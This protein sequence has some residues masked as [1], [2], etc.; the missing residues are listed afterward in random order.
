[1]VNRVMEGKAFKLQRQ[2]RKLPRVLN[3]DTT[4]VFVKHSSAEIPAR[5]KAEGVSAP[6]QPN[7]ELMKGYKHRAASLAREDK[8]G[9]F[10]GQ[11]P[12]NCV[13]RHLERIE[14]HYDADKSFTILNTR[15]HRARVFFNAPRTVYILLYENF[16]Q[17][18]IRSSFPHC[19]KKELVDKFKAS[20]LAWVEFTSPSINSG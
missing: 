15:V 17:Q 11:S 19:D 6:R 20:C 8:P 4:G 13:S 7:A 16:K 9:K 1:M 10:P 5:L 18:I 14:N 3:T 12:G 2:L